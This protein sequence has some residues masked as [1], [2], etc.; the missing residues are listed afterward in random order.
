MN[1]GFSGLKDVISSPHSVYKN[2][3]IGY[4]IGIILGLMKPK[5]L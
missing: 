5:S 4:N 2:S 3:N 1:L